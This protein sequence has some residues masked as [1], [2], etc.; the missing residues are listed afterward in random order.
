MIEFTAVSYTIDLQISKESMKSHSRIFNASNSSTDG[1]SKLSSLDSSGY[2]P[3]TISKGDTD[4]TLFSC[5]G[6]RNSDNLPDLSICWER[7]DGLLLRLYIS[8]GL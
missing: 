1:A 7:S 6:L 5:I 2:C 3:S 4:N 8:T